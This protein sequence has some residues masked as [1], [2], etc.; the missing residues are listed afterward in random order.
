MIINEILGKLS[1]V[2]GVGV[3]TKGLEL[4]T[5]EHW[6]DTSSLGKLETISHGT[7]TLNDLEGP[8]VSLG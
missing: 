2:D 3:T 1:S 6:M 8:I 7:N 4:R 5:V